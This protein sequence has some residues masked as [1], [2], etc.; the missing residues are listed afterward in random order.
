M[1][2]RYVT[3]QAAAF[4]KAVRLGKINWSFEASYNVAPTQQVPVVRYE[5][6]E[7]VGMMMRRDDDAL[8]TDSLLCQGRAAEILDHQRT[9]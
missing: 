6:G 4:E 1:C 5:D 9:N 3:A 7:S 8:G 2:G